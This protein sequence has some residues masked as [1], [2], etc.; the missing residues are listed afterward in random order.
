MMLRITSVE[1]T[2]AGPGFFG[3]EKLHFLS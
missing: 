3:R 1:M 2:K